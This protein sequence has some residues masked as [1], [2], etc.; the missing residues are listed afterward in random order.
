LQHPSGYCA[1][2]HE[3]D[4]FVIPQQAVRAPDSAAATAWDEGRD[5]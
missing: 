3:K 4:F 1:G 5:N 2:N